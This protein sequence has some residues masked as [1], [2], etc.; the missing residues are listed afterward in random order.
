[1]GTTWPG[2]PTRDQLYAYREAIGQPPAWVEVEHPWDPRQDFPQPLANRIRES[3]S[4]PYLRLRL[5]AANLSA[6][7]AGEQEETLRSWAEAIQRF[8]TPVILA[9]SVGDT[10]AA[11]L[12][13]A[14][15]QLM[16][17]LRSEK[18][19]LWVLELTGDDPEAVPL[20]AGF[21]GMDWL[22][23]QLDGDPSGFEEL[24]RR[25]AALNPRVPILV[26][27][28]S[29]GTEGSETVLEGL[30]T[31]QWPQVI[32]WSWAL[33]PEGIPP[34]SAQAWRQHLQ[35]SDSDLWLGEIRVQPSTAS[36]TPTTSPTP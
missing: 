8:A 15:R 9:V 3:G 1:H 14:Y 29:P 26:G 6:L 16:Q 4:V 32:G 34:Q 35:S 2:A 10:E 23:V 13:A 22:S 21:A 20:W 31:Q 33:G 17:T 19:L 25:L 30:E 28:I 24:Y 36:P 27:G 7:A 11:E 12:Q 18:N 5:D